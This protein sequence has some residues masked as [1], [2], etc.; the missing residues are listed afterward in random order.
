[1]NKRKI[2]KLSQII[3][4][5]KIN[6]DLLKYILNKTKALW[7][8]LIKSNIS[9][10]PSCI[11]IELTNHCNLKCCTCPR[12]YS[13]GKNMDLGMMPTEK[14]KQIINETY[15]YLDS[16]GLTG[17]GETF[18]YPH[19]KEIASYVKSKKKS[20]ITSLSTNANI[21]NFIEKVQDVLPYIDTIQV[22]IDGLHETYEKI[23]INA[24]F[25]PFYENI[26]T[27]VPLA[28]QHNVDIVFNMVITK[29][30][31]TQM[32]DVIEF[33]NKLGIKYIY[34]SY[35]NLSS[36][37][38]I[39]I[40]YYD[41]F[42]SDDFI[43]MVNKTNSVIK[44][45]PDMEVLGLEKNDIAGFKNCKFPWS[46]FYISWDGYVVPCCTKPFP[47]ILNF[48]NVFNSKFINIINSSAFQKF[49]KAWRTNKAPIFCNKCN[50]L[51]LHK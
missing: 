10:Y 15:P 17:L 42:Y 21:P 24:N 32:S 47:K 33:A 40:E 46:Y 39:G 50:I 25:N 48:G 29:K 11:M 22:S 14:A 36:V 31:Y 8:K 49:R 13:Y 1:M 19:L 20:I 44:K 7:L 2:N 28:K 30:N 34:L 23:R 26:K 9:V 5:T 18:L 38:D 45:Y 35:F 3:L 6:F 12:E 41:F 37:T 43:K 4:N 27:I 16:I 51:H